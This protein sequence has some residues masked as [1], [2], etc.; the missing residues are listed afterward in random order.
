MRPEEAQREVYSMEELKAKAP[1][2]FGIPSG[3]EGLD[4]LF[5]T[6][7]MEEGRARKVPLG[8]YPYL[9]VMNITGIADTGKSLMAEQ[10]AV[11]QASLG[12][13]V[14]FV[15]VETPKEFLVQGL[16]QRAIAMG[17]SPEDVERHIFIIDAATNHRL[18]ED[19]EGLLDVV[20]YAIREYN[21]KSTI[22]DSITGLFEAKEVLARSIVRKVYNFMKKWRQTCLLISQ[23]R[24]SSEELTAEAAGG[25][26]V[27]HIVDG[28]IVL[29]KKLIQTKFEVNT[30]G[31]PLGSVI[32]LI[33]IDGCRMAGHDS[34][35]Y[36][37]EI[38]ETGLV[39]IL[40]PLE[41]YV[42]RASIKV[43]E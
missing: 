39:R 19:V 43:K 8:G 5:F 26:G 10:F 28:T 42:K 6:V 22:I 4:K 30:Y 3:V 27:A 25:Y 33:R 37:M 20:A 34:R 15:T 31:L 17:I 29:Y 7:E 1:R 24:S 2:I 16:R 9:S 41:E 11:K 36:V 32:R 14:L 21:I 13:R 40:A 38:T 23:K 18:R 12:Y 35:T